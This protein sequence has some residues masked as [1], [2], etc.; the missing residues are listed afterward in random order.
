M[1]NKGCVISVLKWLIVYL[2]SMIIGCCYCEVYVIRVVVCYGL[3]EDK[4]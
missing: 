4:L 1:E 2:F 3:E